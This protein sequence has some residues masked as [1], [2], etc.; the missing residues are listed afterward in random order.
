ML[1]EWGGQLVIV[2][3]TPNTYYQYVTAK[4]GLAYME[5]NVPAT[6]QYV[7]DRDG[8]YRQEGHIEVARQLFEVMIKHGLCTVRKP[9]ADPRAGEV[10]AGVTAEAPGELPAAAAQ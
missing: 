3:Y 9:P 10:A 2:Q 8:H 7:H 6:P 4:Y 5:L 1:A